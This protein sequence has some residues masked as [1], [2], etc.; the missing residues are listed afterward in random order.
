MS[1]EPVMAEGFDSEFPALLE[2]E[3]RPLAS[4]ILALVGDRFVAD[5]LF[6]ATC[7]ELWR[8]RS[9]FRPGTDF[10]AWSRAVGRHVVLRHWRKTGREKVAFSSESL[11]RIAEAYQAPS[12]E[13][14]DDGA[15]SR[16]LATCL[17]AVPRN[18]RDLLERRYARGVPLKD[19]AQE[20][21]RSE[22]GM[23]MK[24]LRLRQKLA[25]CVRSKLRREI[26]HDG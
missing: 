17:D 13:A 1:K 8:I 16:A 2:R 19:L 9:A 23:K 10:G 14:E 22:G 18:D 15:A 21:G 4:F 25:D 3:G 5:D 7:L 11:D 6:Q 24:L 26:R 12:G 20:G